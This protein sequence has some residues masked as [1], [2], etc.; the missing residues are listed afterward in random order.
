M[1][2]T[3]YTCTLCTVHIAIHPCRTGSILLNPAPEE[4]CSHVYM[5]TKQSDILGD[6][7]TCTVDERRLPNQLRFLVLL[8]TFVSFFL[9][10]DGPRPL[11]CATEFTTG[12]FTTVLATHTWL[13]PLPLPL[14]SPP[15]LQ[16]HRGRV[17]IRARS[18]W[19]RASER[20]NSI[21]AL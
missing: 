7:Y 14:S 18:C 13:K 16:R 12:F 4:Q 9:L 3:T 5:D 2:Y 21:I 8:C 10:S 6:R 1:I 17:R 11:P 15:P 20:H 19:V